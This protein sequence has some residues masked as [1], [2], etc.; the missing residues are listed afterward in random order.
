MLLRD[1]VCKPVLGRKAKTAL[2][3]ATRLIHR[4]AAEQIRGTMP[5][6]TAYSAGRI[7]ILSW[8]RFCRVIRTGSSSGRS[9]KQND[10][11]Q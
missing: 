10:L 7:A 3:A 5:I 1:F 4:M 8:L 11:A 9:G 2:Q 6:G